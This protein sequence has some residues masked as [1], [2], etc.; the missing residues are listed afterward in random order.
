M[1]LA[2][3]ACKNAKAGDK[4]LKLS[5]SAGLF[6]HVMP[7]GAKYWRMKYRFQGKE[8][9]LALGV[10]PDAAPYFSK[11]CHIIP[12]STAQKCVMG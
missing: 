7:G 4:A 6:L 8:N 5:D 1:S 10:Y 3:L 9:R 11:T 12:Q 2:N